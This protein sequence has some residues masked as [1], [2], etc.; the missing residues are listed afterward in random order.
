MEVKES[1]KSLEEQVSA[2]KDPVLK[3]AA[4]EKLLDVLLNTR[5]KSPRL[6]NEPRRSNKTSKIVNGLLGSSLYF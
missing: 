2:I 6:L 5:R 4:F 3:K 1:L